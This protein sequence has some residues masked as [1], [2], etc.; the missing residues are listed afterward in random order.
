MDHIC[1]LTSL[2]RLLTKFLSSI[3]KS[4]VD[5]THLKSLSL[6]VNEL[7]NYYHIQPLTDLKGLE[8]LRLH[9]ENWSRNHDSHI[10]RILLK[11]C[12][13]TLRSIEIQTKTLMFDEKLLVLLHEDSKSGFQNLELLDIECKRLPRNGIDLFHK[14]ID[15]STL[16]NLSISGL[17]QELIPF[18]NSCTKIFTS[19]KSVSLSGLS[20]DMDTDTGKRKIHE[21]EKPFVDTV[22]NLLLSFSHLRSLELKNLGR[23]FQ[24]MSRLFRMGLEHLEANYSELLPSILRAIF[25]HA[26][27]VTLKFSYSN[28]RSGPTCPS[29]SGEMVG[30]II[31]H[32]PLLEEFTFPP[33]VGEVVRDFTFLFFSNSR[34]MYSLL[35][36][37]AIT[38]TG[39][40]Q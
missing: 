16:R 11:N 24:D 28:A 29:L 8:N 2:S 25:T 22:M 14:I 36:L 15:I 20:I 18:I 23:T 35:I 26:N 3:C 21:R 12:M 33:M 7:I 27:L 37:S 38:R 34:L 32:L 5:R 39:R 4:L 30:Q 31:R 1:N 6:S 17:G 9:G 40:N 10:A 19:A 13:T